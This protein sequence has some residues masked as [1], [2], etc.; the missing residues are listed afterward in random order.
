MEVINNGEDG[1]VVR[2]KLNN[3][4]AALEAATSP[5]VAGTA[6]NID[7]D[8]LFIADQ[9]GSPV[10]ITTQQVSGTPLTQKMTLAKNHLRDY[11]DF[12][13]IRPS[14]A[15]TT[16]GTLDL[17]PFRVTQSGTGA[18]AGQASD[19]LVYS[20]GL[21]LVTGT[22][23]TGYVVVE[24]L[25]APL[26]FANGTSNFDFR[27]E[28]KLANLP[29]SGGENYVFKAGFFAQAAGVTTHEMTFNLDSSSPN[30][31]STVKASTGSSRP[32]STIAAQTTTAVALRVWYDPAEQRTR[33]FIDSV[34][35]PGVSDYSRV[36]DL[37]TVLR[38]GFILT[39]TQNTTS[40]SV[41]VNRM[42]TDI[43]SP[44]VSHF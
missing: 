2:N 24:H 13:K 7:G 37:F 39:K 25:S 21:E 9:D 20:G 40:R 14:F 32:N 41:Y 34:E 6:T 15:S 28:V 35:V 17:E 26:T 4:F 29:V 22:T 10:D 19:S 38:A 43:L 16:G 5:G 1:L 31:L 36:V 42:A 44:A 18:R 33:F 27:A 23:S 12:Y 11:T 3:N 30:W 8:E